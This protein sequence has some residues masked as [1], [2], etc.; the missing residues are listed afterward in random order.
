MSENFSSNPQ[1]FSYEGE[2]F[3]RT[4]HS[5]FAKY[6]GLFSPASLVLSYVDWLS[7]LRI[8][9][10]K[11]MDIVK[12][13]G[14]KYLI[15]LRENYFEAEPCDVSGKCEPQDPRFQHENW[16]DYPFNLYASIF[17]L[18]EDIWSYATQNVHGVSKHHM[19]IVHFVTRQI[20]DLISPSNFP[21]AN[22]EVLAKTA[23]Q[24][25][26]NLVNGFKFLVDDYMRFVTQAPV[27]D[28]D[29]F[30]V[31][32]DVAVTPGKVIFRNSLIE[33]IQYSRKLCCPV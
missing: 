20:L 30:K 24:A 17:L 19:Q 31:G 14:E 10:A 5:I 1:A 15:W 4:L 13:A 2:V 21:W 26:S 28:A 25:G 27:F 29:K 32:V 9:P 16:N 6:M 23:E 11:Q 7:H 18:H 12:Y 8:C 3:D 22:P 33:L